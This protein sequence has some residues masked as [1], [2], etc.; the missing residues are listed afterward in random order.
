MHSNMYVLVGTPCVD[1]V[2]GDEYLCVS[3]VDSSE[4]VRAWSRSPLWNRGRGSGCCRSVL[5]G[6]A[7]W[8]GLDRVLSLIFVP[9][10]NVVQPPGDTA[11]RA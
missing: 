9:S 7:V 8:S 10:D 4:C 1:D 2:R 6:A 5:T 3:V 11:T